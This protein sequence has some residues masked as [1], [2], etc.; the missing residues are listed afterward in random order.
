MFG[1]I[2]ITCPSEFVETLTTTLLKKRLAA[3]IN[4]LPAVQSWYWWDNTICSKEESLLL[5]KTHTSRFCKLEQIVKELH[6]Y[7]VP[8]IVMLPIIS[9]TDDYLNWISQEVND[10]VDS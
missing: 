8:S 4:I 6:P 5:V 3:A 10:S 1:I 2:M 9:G 7:Q